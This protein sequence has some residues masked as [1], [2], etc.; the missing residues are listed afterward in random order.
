LKGWPEMFDRTPP[1]SVQATTSTGRVLVMHGQA[2]AFLAR[3]M[4]ERAL[5][6]M[7]LVKP[8]ETLGPLQ[9]YVEPVRSEILDVRKAPGT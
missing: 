4:M 3:K 7:F 9:P 1:F 2:S 5:P 6:T 8:G